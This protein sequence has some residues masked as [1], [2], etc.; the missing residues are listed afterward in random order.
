[1]IRNNLICSPCANHAQTHAAVPWSHVRTLW[2]VL[3]AALLAMI[4]ARPAQAQASLT[5][6]DASVESAA[7]SGNGN[8]V[9][10][11]A[12]A[13]SQSATITSLS[14]YV[15]RASGNLILA[16]YDATGVR[17]GPGKLLAATSSFA[18]AT[19][20]NTANV[21]KPVTVA[22]GNYWLVY[23]P[24]SSNLTFRKQNNSGNCVY[25]A[26]S[27]SRGM[28]ATFG[29]STAG[30]TPTTW[31]FY[32]TLVPSADNVASGTGSGSGSSGGSSG[33]SGSGGPPAVNGVCG[34]ANG[35]AVSSPPSSNLCSTGSASTVAGNGPW[36]WMCVG[37]N[38][39]TTS[40]CQAPLATVSGGGTG[41]GGGSGG[42]S[43]GTGGGGGASGGGAGSPILFQHIASSTDPV[44]SGIPGS[45][46]VFHTESLPANTVAVM[47]VSA[48]SGRTVSISDSL[49][50][51][52]SGAVCAVDAGSGGQKSWVF[53]QSLGA[54]GGADKITINVGSGA[55]QPVQF[56]ISFYENINTSSPTNGFLCPSSPITPS[57]AGVISPGSFTPTANNNANG[58]NVIW[59][60]T[61]LGCAGYA[62]ATVTGWT[63]GPSFNLLNG[64]GVLWPVNG[65]P[66]ASQAYVQTS[67]SSV[68]P[69]IT[70]SGENATNGDCFNSL[71]VAL[72][73]ANNGATAPTTIHVA[74]I[75]HESI[76]IATDPTTRSPFPTTGNLRVL[77]TT[78]PDGQPT[79]GGATLSS[80]TSSDGCAWTIVGNGANG[81]AVQGYAQNCAPCP[82]CTVSLHF[83]GSGNVSGS[84]RLYDVTNANASSY[85][86]EA[87]GNA[88]CGTTLSAAPT[89]S[90]AVSAG[91]TIASVGVGTGPGLS[92]SS[93][94]GATFDLWT[95]AGQTDTDTADN[96]DLQAHYYFSTGATQNWNWT[97][98]NPSSCYWVAA[99][100]K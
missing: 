77:A 64:G 41:G 70:A 48:P 65:F 72:Q 2:F 40:S 34:S 3:I 42:G 18:T 49:A 30:C 84:F 23:L 31:S 95:Y 69:S 93:P 75:T 80:I 26:Q 9:L 76:Y 19:G 59:N 37:S 83:S 63:A 73:V 25:K 33:G 32:A 51:S 5:I 45:A 12:A 89:I 47:G 38:G 20:W 53:V 98:N 82:T 100:Y 16:V 85:Q 54:N 52:W 78:W 35:V 79:G 27:F 13:L 46:F 90:P 71:S 56:D 28:P 92:A 81:D 15:T 74:N 22:A 60:Y 57:S 6:G 61:P 4:V 39:G 88:A 55:T 86:N 99:I 43:G 24:S 68:T 17:G 67:Q 87:S 66:Q 50:G 58:G 7:D 1:M 94:A 36:N 96:A 14:F 21:S 29:S 91:L 62:N 8:L 11:Q 44:G 10:A 97:L